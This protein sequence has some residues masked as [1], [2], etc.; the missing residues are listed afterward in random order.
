VKIHRVQ[1]IAFSSYLIETPT[2]LFLVD[3][4]FLWFE[5]LVLRKIRE[6]GRRADEL[7]LVLVTH[8]HLD[9][10]GAVAA[11]TRHAVFDIAAHP[12]SAEVL[13]GGGRSY[14]PPRRG[15]TR[16]VE[17][18]ATV[19]MPLLR[20]PSITPTLAPGDGERLDGHGLPGAVY[21]TPGHSEWCITL[22]LDDGTAFAGDLLIGPGH[23]TSVVA[24]PAMATD[25]SQA[26]GSMRKVLA[27]GAERFKP[28]HGREFGADE[29]RAALGRLEARAIA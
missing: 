3:S 16:A 13:A 21:H 28:A 23:M 24:P 1:G 10:M 15:W 5:P 4:G 29:V 27:A 22:V 11:L 12:D 20:L 19:G 14:S 18:L 6:I 8:P 9:H 7:K 26:A 25:L 17:L 2:S